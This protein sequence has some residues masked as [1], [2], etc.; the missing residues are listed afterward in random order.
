MVLQGRV[1]IVTGGARGIGQEYCAALAREGAK[2]VAA[3][4]LSSAETVGKIRQAGGEAEGIVADVS[5]ERDTQAMADLA[6]RRFGRV[7]ILVNNAALLARMKPFDQITETEWDR[8]MAVNV[9]GLWQCCKAVVPIMR[10][11]SKGKIINVSSSTIWVGSPMILHYV[12]SKGAVLAFTRALARELS[13]SGINVNAITPGYTM[14]P[15]A[16]DIG[17]KESIEALKQ[18]ILE[19]RIVKRFEQPSD[20]AGTVLFL[21]SDASDFISGQVINCDGGEAHH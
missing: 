2:V 16:L 3:D 4:V 11:Q 8:L 10:R 19:I 18:H 14:T 20:L 12:A 21:A 1:A 9:K 17:D 15:A 5:V 13:G 6:M 7:D